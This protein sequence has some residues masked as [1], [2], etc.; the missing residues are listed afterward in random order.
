M[1]KKDKNVIVNASLNSKGMEKKLD[2]LNK[3]MSK[4]RTIVNINGND[5]RYSWHL[6]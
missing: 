3:T 5:S 2:R 4:Q 1:G 6:N